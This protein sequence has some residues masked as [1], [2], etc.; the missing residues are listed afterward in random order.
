MLQYWSYP[1][2]RQKQSRESGN[3]GVIQCESDV[4]QFIITVLETAHIECKNRFED[5]VIGVLILG[6]AFFL[7]KT[8]M[9]SGESAG[10][11]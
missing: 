9:M 1:T 7:N 5:F 10:M 11:F 3:E 4:C 6:S 8:S 2:W